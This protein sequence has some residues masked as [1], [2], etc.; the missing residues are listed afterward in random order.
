MK[1]ITL[2]TSHGDPTMTRFNSALLLQ[3]GSS[4]YLFEA[5]SPV[6]AMMIRKNLPFADLK[7]VF[8]SHS[9]EDHIGGLPG[10]IKS[11]IK[12]PEERQHTTF[13]LPEQIV[14]DAVKLFMEA[15]HR[16]AGD[17]LVSYSLIS[18]GLIYQDE[19]IRVEAVRT[20]HMAMEA[21]E[22]DI[23]S[24]AFVVDTA[25]KRIVFTGD[26]NRKLDDLPLEAL[27][28][29]SVCVMEC[30]HYDPSIAGKILRGLPIERFI[31]VHVS[32]KW[33][34]LGEAAFVEALGNP[35][36]PVT[37]ASDGMEFEL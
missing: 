16:P 36:F 19:N 18:E 22:G 13:M 6:N 2:G 25:E 8:V 17:D 37:V 32:N 29:P 20:K 11:L 15:T 4:S 33:D 27:S 34:A 26:I 28:V 3:I 24:Y 7:A 30:Q 21:K 31:G 10:L 14:I 23:P 1:L 5:G 35:P 12:R 9:H